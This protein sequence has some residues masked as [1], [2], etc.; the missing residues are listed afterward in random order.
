MRSSSL[1][2]VDLD[3][4]SVEIYAFNV[5][6]IEIDLELLFERVARI[7]CQLVDWQTH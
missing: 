5:E 3:L 6:S 7:D 4:K 1:S 2:G